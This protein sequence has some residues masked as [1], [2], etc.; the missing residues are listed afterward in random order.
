MMKLE[1]D[2]LIK[3]PINIVAPLPNEGLRTARCVGGVIHGLGFEEQ[4]F[5]D[6]NA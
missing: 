2:P 6:N 3:Q 1:I 4:D 5:S